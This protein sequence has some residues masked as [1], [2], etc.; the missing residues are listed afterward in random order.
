MNEFLG[1]L[2]MEGLILDIIFITVLILFNGF[3]TGSEIAIISI[4]Q[5]ILDE[6]I[7][8]GKG[9]ALL[10]ANLKKQPDRFFATVQI[11]VTLLSTLAS[12]YGGSRLVRYLHP[13]LESLSLSP[14]HTGYIEEAALISMVLMI[15]YLS[16]VFGELIPKSLAL[17]YATNFS[18]LVAYPLYFFS[19]I[20]S[21]FTFF[22]TLSS[23][24]V[25][26]LFHK[27]QTSFSETRLHEEE[28]RQILQE[29]VKVGTIEH[30]EQQIISNVFEIN[31]TSAR[32]IMTP[33][34]NLTALSIEAPLKE[35]ESMVF[36]GKHSRIPV[37]Q[38]SLDKME[39]ILHV[40][41]YMRMRIQGSKES[42]EELLRPAYYVPESMKIDKIL[43]EMRRR[44]TQMAIVV[45]EYG[46]TAGVV[47]M[48]DILEEIVGDIQD[49]AES[50]SEQPILSLPTGRHLILGSCSIGEF[51]EYFPSDKI[52]ESE[53]YNS[54]AGFIIEEAGCFPE[55]GEKVKFAQLEFELLRRVRQKLV[56]FRL[57][58][59]PS[60]I[61]IEKQSEEAPQS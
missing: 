19:R 21:G 47:S 6:M 46:G 20:F 30:S 4:K 53:G 41:D 12:V 33:R 2:P 25:L 7:K 54:I 17:R 18:L 57:N 45:D 10:I 27:G 49:A 55:V 29:G 38:E 35:I 56:Q 1:H 5:V 48:E 42:I 32:E 14:Q 51:N 9:R 3:F 15:S 26:A 50:P 44:R 34:V 61:E 28:I 39:G 23:N 58:I 31:D 40:K 59:L 11:G 16:L 43:E 8:Q 36:D 24:L 52:P 22:L 13:Y 60:S 37:F